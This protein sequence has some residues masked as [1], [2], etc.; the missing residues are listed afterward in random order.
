M[1]GDGTE[2]MLL[3]SF[4]DMPVLGQVGLKVGNSR[5]VLALRKRDGDVE[6]QTT[7]SAMM[8]GVRGMRG[9][10]GNHGLSARM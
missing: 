10:R 2:G 4:D 6:K 1:K 7:I 8:M 3:K 5:D 9:M